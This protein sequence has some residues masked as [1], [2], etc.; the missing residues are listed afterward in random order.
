MFYETMEDLLPTMK[1]Y[2]V[3]E[4]GTQKL[5]P[6]DDFSKS[7]PVQSTVTESEEAAE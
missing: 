7:V 1:I 2:I 6:L 5:L 3:D 4:S